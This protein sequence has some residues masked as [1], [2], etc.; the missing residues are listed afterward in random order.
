V[1]IRQK[2]HVLIISVKS[3]NEVSVPAAGQVAEWLPDNRRL[4]LWSAGDRG[5]RPA[6]VAIDASVPE[7]VLEIQC[8]QSPVLSGSDSAVVCIGSDKAMLTRPITGGATRRIATAGPVGTLI[9]GSADGRSVFSFAQDDPS[10]A[11]FAIDLT[12]GRMSIARELRVSD[13]TGMWRI[14]PVL[15]TPDR[16]VLAYS[17]GRQLDELYVYT[18]L[19]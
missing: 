6:I 3:G 17:L 7:I 1:A 14:W 10:A 9:G 8:A 4:L 15:L 18:G 13:P 12:S 11:V 5:G 2:N 19:R 16:R